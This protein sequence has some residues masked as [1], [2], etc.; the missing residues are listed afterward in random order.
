M[1][2]LILIEAIPAARSRFI[3]RLSGKSYPLDREAAFAAT[4]SVNGQ[5]ERLERIVSGM[6]ITIAGDVF[7]RAPRRKSPT[8]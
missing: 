7:F 2:K 3:N 4:E 5:A 6:V 1:F 8:H